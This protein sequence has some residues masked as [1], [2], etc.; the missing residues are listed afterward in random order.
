LSLSVLH[1]ESSLAVRLEIAFTK[2][3]IASSADLLIRSAK[4]EMRPWFFSNNWKISPDLL[5]WLGESRDYGK[6]LPNLISSRFD[7]SK[8]TIK[9]PQQSRCVELMAEL[10][11][12]SGDA[13]RKLFSRAG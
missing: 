1:L 12:A 2:L 11:E 7:W 13:R 10:G 4:W 5:S 6:Q 9:D 3:E 8:V